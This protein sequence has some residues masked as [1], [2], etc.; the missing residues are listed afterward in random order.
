VPNHLAGWEVEDLPI[1][2]SPEMQN[3]VED[4]L[5]YDDSLFRVYRKGSTIVMV[6]VAYWSPGKYAYNRVVTH[7]PDTCWVVNGW[8]R[9]DREYSVEKRIGDLQLKPLEF[10]IFEK[11][12]NVQ[13]VIFW[14]LVGGKPYT[15]EQFGWDRNVMD[16]IRRNMLFLK[17]WS[18][19]G[20]DQQEEQ[21]FIRISS[22]V[23]FEKLWDDPDFIR[24]LNDIE[25]LGIAV[26]RDD[27]RPVEQASLTF[28]DTRGP[29][30]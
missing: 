11:D 27:A 12:G 5:R 16:K 3:R 26:S 21:F 18:A 1:A 2:E 13:E 28:S 22:N 20:F 19:F 25:A 7:T 30:L 6:Y 29:I 9:L 17:D 4:I 14:H 15:H 8:E 10:G 23:S 24:L